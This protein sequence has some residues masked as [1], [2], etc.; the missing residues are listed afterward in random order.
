MVTEEK[1]IELSPD[2]RDYELVLIVNP[3]MSDEALD[4]TIEKVSRLIT[5][6]GGVL[7]DTQKW[8]KRKLAYPIKRLLEGNYVLLK[9][10]MKPA[11]SRELEAT[12]RI[13]EEVVRHLLV[14]V[15]S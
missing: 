8:G 9:C 14:K 3:E 2:L 15:E 13:S 4:A 11:S 1:V 12:L 7:T 6:R 5:G 10:K